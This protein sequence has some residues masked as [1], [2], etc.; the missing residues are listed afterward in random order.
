MVPAD[1]TDLTEDFLLR[2]VREKKLGLISSFNFPLEI[3][4]CQLKTL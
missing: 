1:H 2:N 4:T 3:E